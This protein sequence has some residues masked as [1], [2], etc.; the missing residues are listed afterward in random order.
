MTKCH[1]PFQNYTAEAVQAMTQWAF[2]Q[3]DVV[4]AEAET[5]PENKVSQ[6]VS[7]KC[8][9]VPDGTTGEEGSRF[10]PERLFLQ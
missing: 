4:F 3:K 10:V 2:Q 1:A 6:R 5:E 7:E 9:F 8:G